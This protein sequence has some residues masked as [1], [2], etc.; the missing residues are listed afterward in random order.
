MSE[1]KYYIC[2]IAKVKTIS[3]DFYGK[4]RVL[5]EP[6][7]LDFEY[8][9]YGLFF[10]K[11]EKESIRAFY[12]YEEDGKFYE[13]FSGIFLTDKLTGVDLKDSVNENFR[14]KM[15][16]KL[17]LT[18]KYYND[19][20]GSFGADFQCSADKFAES[21]KEIMKWKDIIAKTVDE[22]LKK[23]HEEWIMENEEKLKKEIVAEEKEQTSAA[24]LDEFI[25]NRK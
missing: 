12:F 5:T 21:V 10:P 6:A 13:F 15:E 23:W 11:T 7:S 25:R 16:S 8:E 2:S 17:F 14:L 19:E 22:C 1:R 4:G 3:Y 9:T 24:W 18:T 20:Y